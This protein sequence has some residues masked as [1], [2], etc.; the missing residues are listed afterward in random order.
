MIKLDITKKLPTP[1]TIELRQGDH[2]DL[3]EFAVYDGAASLDLTGYSVTFK[4][5]RPDGLLVTGKCSVTDAAKGRCAYEVVSNLTAA[6]GEVETAYVELTKSGEVLTS[7]NMRMKI[8]EDADLTVPSGGA[9][10]PA[11]D[12]ALSDAATA[13]DAA[14]KAT[15]NADA[16]TAE[17]YAAANEA[18]QAVTSPLLPT[19]NVPHGHASGEVVTV[20]DAFKGPLLPDERKGT[21]PLVM[22]GN[23]QQVTTTGKN[24]FQTTNDATDNTNVRGF[25]GTVEQDGEW[26][27]LT[28]TGRDVGF[29]F[30]KTMTFEAG[31]TYAVSF[32]G[33]MSVTDEF[34]YLFF[35]G[36]ES[37]N[38]ELINR[39]TSKNLMASADEKRISFKITPTATYTGGLLVG[40]AGRTAGETLWVKNLQVE[41]DSV[42]DYEPYTGGYASPS[43]DWPQPITALGAADGNDG[44]IPLTVRGRNALP[45]AEA[46]TTTHN[47]ITFTSDGEG[48]YTIK[49]TA[50]GTAASYGRFPVE[51]TTIRDEAYVHLRNEG[52]STNAAIGFFRP[53]LTQADWSSFQVENFVAA[54]SLA[55]ETIAYVNLVVNP[56]ATVDITLTPSLEA[57]DE[58]TDFTPYVEPSTALIDLQGEELAKL[59]DG[60]EDTLTVYGDGSVAKKKRIGKIESYAGEEIEGEWLSTTGELSEGSTVYYALA[61]P[62]EI[63]LGSMA[64]PEMVQHGYNSMS[65]DANLPAEIDV[66]Y[67]VHQD[68]RHEQTMA[69]IAALM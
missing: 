28:V 42:T 46:G 9:Y 13:T 3:L 68:I 32:D 8:I 39:V 56:G 6:V 26:L 24:L 16:A 2:G 15:S 66:T 4:A 43:P 51:A 5:Y 34:D 63:D 49:G 65:A 45:A 17:A 59:P 14:N 22:H 60:T 69:A 55:G 21:E 64:L 35:M 44:K 1:S 38:V 10:I 23:M 27:K 12:S 48:T 11:L 54:K 19:G 53:D 47:G 37:G 20:T 67:Q 36:T 25:S 41:L 18:R 30:L 7:Q 62:E 52:R 50:T 29:Y 61:A 58:V 31:K 57:T 40:S 33:K